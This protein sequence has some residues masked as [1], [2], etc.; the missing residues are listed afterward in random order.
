MVDT[1][2]DQ[3]L[4]ELYD[5]YWMSM[6]R[7]ATLLLGASDQAEEIV[8]DAFVAIYPR[9]A[10]F[11]ST[12][13]AVAYLRASVV[14]G[15]RSSHRHRQVV[16]RYRPN[17]EP[18]PPTPEESAVRAESDARMMAALRRLPQRQ[19][20]VLVL[21]YYGEASEAEIAQTLGI[22]RGAVKSHAHRGLE[23]LRREMSGQKA[24]A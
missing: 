16:N 11:G 7:L 2:D 22:T 18:G 23:A 20:E 12:P 10:M 1:S 21:R 14:N 13:Q 9:R 17:P 24:G 15:C 8:Q 5:G 3:W 19:Q 6:V 4:R